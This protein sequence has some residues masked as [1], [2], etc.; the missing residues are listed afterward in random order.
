MYLDYE[1]RFGFHIR[2]CTFSNPSKPGANP[3]YPCLEARLVET[4]RAIT[5]RLNWLLNENLYWNWDRGPRRG[6][7]KIRRGYKRLST[8]SATGQFSVGPRLISRDTTFSTSVTTRRIKIWCFH[9]DGMR[10]ICVCLVYGRGKLWMIM[11]LKSGLKIQIVS[12]IYM[13]IGFALRT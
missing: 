4:R 13:S 9:L 1:F 5:R 3:K 12:D 10:K 8:T 6:Y 2:E 11:R 7:M